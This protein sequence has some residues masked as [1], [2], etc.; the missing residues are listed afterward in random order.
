MGTRGTPIPASRKLEAA[1]VS[2]KAE[3][4]ARDSHNQRS[5]LAPKSHVSPAS[6]V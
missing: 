2:E 4:P 6:R 3:H 5:R 1:P